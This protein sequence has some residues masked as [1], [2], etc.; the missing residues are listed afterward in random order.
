MFQ[1]LKSILNSFWISF[2]MNFSGKPN[3]TKIDQIT[4][5]KTLVFSVLTDGVILWISYRAF[6]TSDLSF[7]LTKFPFSD[8]NSLSKTDYL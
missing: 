3:T 4:S 1:A 5:Y 2:A 7:V 6:V 8:L